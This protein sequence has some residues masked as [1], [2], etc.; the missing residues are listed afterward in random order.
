[1]STRESRGTREGVSSVSTL[2]D[3][4]RR[5]LGMLNQP[6]ACVYVRRKLFGLEKSEQRTILA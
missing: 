6:N 4:M 1:M 2:R 5:A 3:E